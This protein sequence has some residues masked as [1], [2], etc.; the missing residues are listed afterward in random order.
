MLRL[1]IM[2]VIEED[3]G[4]YIRLLE[5][6]PE[7]GGRGDGGSESGGPAKQETETIPS[8]TL[9]GYLKGGRGEYIY[10]RAGT[11]CFLL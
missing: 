11:K 8:S 7:D 9:L 10:T 5:W 4:G 2:E 6:V 1:K 3:Q